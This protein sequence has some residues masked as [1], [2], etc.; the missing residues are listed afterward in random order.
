LEHHCTR[1]PDDN[2][3]IYLSNTDDRLVL[4]NS[5]VRNSAVEQVGR[6]WYVPPENI[7]ITYTNIQDGWEG[8]GNIDEDPLFIDATS[9]DPNDWDLNLRPDSPCIDA[10]SPDTRS[11]SEDDLTAVLDGDGDGVAVRDMGAFEYAPLDG[12]PVIAT[13]RSE[14][15]FSTRTGGTNPAA[16]ELRIYNAGVG[17]LD[18]VVREDP[19]CDWLS[20][21]R[22]Q[23]SIV[24][25]GQT[26]PVL[27][28]VNAIG[29][30]SGN[31]R[32][33]LG[34]EAQQALNSPMIVPV[35]L[36]IS[37][38]IY[39]PESYPTIQSAI[40]AAESSGAIIVSPGIYVEN[41]DFDG[42]DLVLSSLD[43]ED[44]NVVSSTVIDADQAGSVV[45]FSGRETPFCQLSGFTIT[46]GHTEGDGGGINGHG[47][48]ATIENCAIIDNTVTGGDSNGGGI[49][50]CDGII[51]SCLIQGN[52]G[53]GEN[54]EGA[55]LS[56]CDGIIVNCTITDNQAIGADSLGGGLAV[57]H[58]TIR[59]CVI[60]NNVAQENGGGAYSCSGDILNCVVSA[61]TSL[62]DN[63]GGLAYVSGAIANCLVSGNRAWLYGGGLDRC[64]GPICHCTIVDNVTQC[65]GGGVSR[66]YGAI[67]NCIITDNRAGID[68][69]QLWYSSVPSHSCFPGARHNGNIDA[70]PGFVNPGYWDPNGAPWDASD[71]IWHDGDYHLTESSACLDAGSNLP[72]VTTDFSGTPRP[73]DGDSDGLSTA[74]MGCVL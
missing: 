52:Q 67:A 72:E 46:G 24:E 64:T 74:D 36:R 12:A 41:I 65:W 49:A 71:D 18:L 26:L 22:K 48:H 27:L 44:V 21:S 11:L 57:C 10:G 55:G 70:D 69:Q 37:E 43:P 13:D 17:V 63:G 32:C 28:N 58:G 38:V 14:A 4:V 59:D 66:S 34:I 61:N 56:G 47:T 53:L 73:V 3:A 30:S 33:D 8:L 50:D 5:I 19:P 40:D 2:P 25:R 45:I 7:Q 60:T 39:V 23:G 1:A 29:L 16:Q 20:L 31:H 62:W 6:L 68:G 42:K 9:A 54:S 51:R 35:E 15:V